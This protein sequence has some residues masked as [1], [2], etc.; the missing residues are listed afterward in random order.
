MGAGAEPRREGAPLCPP[1]PASVLTCGLS[2]TKSVMG[3]S[4]MQSE[5]RRTRIHRGTMVPPRWN[6]G[7][8]AR[9]ERG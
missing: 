2:A 4:F 6:T 9:A 7:I 8:W 1:G 5:A 3:S